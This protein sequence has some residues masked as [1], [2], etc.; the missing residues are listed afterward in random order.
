MLATLPAVLVFIAVFLAG[1]RV[2]PLRGVIKDRRTIVSFSAGM[3]IAY[4]FVRMMPELHGARELLVESA[5]GHAPLPFEGIAIYFLALVGFLCFYGLDRLR[6]AQ[7]EGPLEHEGGERSLANGHVAGLAA[8]VGLMSYLL[9]RDAGE[10]GSATALYT[11][12]FGAHFL[13]LDHALNEE[14]G[15]VY[16]R[17]GRWFMAGSCLLGWLLGVA[18]VLPEFP[19]SLLVAFI[20]GGVIMTNT[21]MELSEGRDGRFLPFVAGSLLYGLVLVPLA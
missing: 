5:S 13:G 2:H 1:E 10:S 7:S 9:V 8:Y 17:R 12:A 18:I 16:R 15:D 6:P 21:L 14:Y 19:L 11:L 3:S 20:S 4:V